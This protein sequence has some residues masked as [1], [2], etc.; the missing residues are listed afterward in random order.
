MGTR[1]DIP[2]LAV[3]ACFTLICSPNRGYCRE[4]FSKDTDLYLHRTWTTENGLPQNSVTSIV[5][6]QDGYLWLGTFGG[7]ARFD[8]VDFTVFNTINTAG[9]KSD[10]I[11]ALYEDAE[12]DLWIGTEHGGLTRYHR[13]VFTNYSLRAV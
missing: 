12:G 9:I 5:Q 2:A 11:R 1:R 6:A 8:G 3:L 4:T 10:R 7:L 13:G